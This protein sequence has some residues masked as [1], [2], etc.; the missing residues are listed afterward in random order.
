[1]TLQKKVYPF[2]GIRN[3]TVFWNVHTAWYIPYFLP[4]RCSE[5]Y[6]MWSIDIHITRHAHARNSAPYKILHAALLHTF[7]S[8]TAHTQALRSWTSISD[9]PSLSSCVIPVSA[10]CVQVQ[11]Y[12]SRLI[13]PYQ[14]ISNQIWRVYV[15]NRIYCRSVTRKL[16]IIMKLPL[17]YTRYK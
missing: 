10:L 3:G 17:T 1:M 13:K 14:C 9:V 11:R 12:W 5:M 6:G 2:S 7:T 16:Q 8:F 4:L 15:G